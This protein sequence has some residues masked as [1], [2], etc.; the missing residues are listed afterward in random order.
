MSLPECMYTTILQGG[1][2][3]AETPCQKWGGSVFMKF[4]IYIHSEILHSSFDPLT[5][6]FWGGSAPLIKKWGGGAQAPLPPGSLP[7]ILVPE[8]E[9]IIVCCFDD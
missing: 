4:T 1:F 8:S 2:S 9:D 3:E 5:T 7:L 6:K